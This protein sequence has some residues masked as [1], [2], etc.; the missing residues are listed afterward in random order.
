M[1]G[2]R[3]LLA[4]F[5][6]FSLM[7]AAT[8]SKANEFALGRERAIESCAG[9]HQVTAQQS[10]PSPVPFPEENARVVPPT[11]KAIS[12][13][14][15]GHEKELRAFIVAPDHPMKEQQFLPVDLNAIIAYIKKAKDWWLRPTR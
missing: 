8:T 11:F 10:Q 7:G 1:L 12:I 6:S 3:Y 4:L 15:Q 9:C 5:L 2:E 13:K 14:Y